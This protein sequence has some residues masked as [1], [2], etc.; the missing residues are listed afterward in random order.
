MPGKDTTFTIDGAQGTYEA[1]TNGKKCKSINSAQ[2]QAQTQTISHSR[3]F[4]EHPDNFPIAHDS[5]RGWVV[6]GL[7]ENERLH[8]ILHAC[9]KDMMVVE[10]NVDFTFCRL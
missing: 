3:R 1:D 10:L 8:S 6:V 9:E 5:E 7:E 2:Y 4:Q